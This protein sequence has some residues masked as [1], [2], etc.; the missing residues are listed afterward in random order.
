VI[1][2]LIVHTQSYGYDCRLLHD[3]ILLLFGKYAIILERQYE[4]T[5]DEVRF[6]FVFEV[7]LRLGTRSFL[8]TT[9]P[10]YASKQTRI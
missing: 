5:F 8:K 10:L 9:T 2:L 7:E 6:L 3:L 4:K 1:S